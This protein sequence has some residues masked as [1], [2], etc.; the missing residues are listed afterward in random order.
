MKMPRQILELRIF[1]ESF[2]GRQLF[3]HSAWISS[4]NMRLYTDASSLHGFAAMLGNKWIS[5]GWRKMFKSEDI[6]LLEFFPIMLAVD[7]W[8]NFFQNKHVVFMTDNL[9]LVS[10]I[11]SQTCKCSRIMKLI[12]H[13]AITCMSHNVLFNAQHIP[14]KYNVVADNLSRC[15]FQKAKQW[16]PWLD[17]TSTPVP[18]HLA[19]AVWL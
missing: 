9:A 13:F 12:R 15:H 17:R 10:I 8:E 4:E 5:G 7:I 1:L 14:G 2:N 6:T 3:L 19:P 16:A 18:A 11:N